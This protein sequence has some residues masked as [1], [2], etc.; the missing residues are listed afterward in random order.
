M[1]DYVL[2]IFLILFS[3]AFLGFAYTQVSKQLHRLQ[4]YNP[5]KASVIRT[6]IDKRVSYDDEQQRKRITYAPI[7]RYQY[8]TDGQTYESNQVHPIAIASNKAWAKS[9]IEPYR[10]GNSVTIYVDPEDPE[11]AYLIKHHSFFPYIFALGSMVFLSTGV[12]IFMN[13]W[14]DD[15]SVATKSPSKTEDSASRTG[16]LPFLKIQDLV[17]LSLWFI[18]G[19]ITSGHYFMNAPTSSKLA[20]TI[21]TIYF[22]MGLAMLLYFIFSERTLF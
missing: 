17:M 15:D 2:S 3:F 7:V 8:Q 1:K 21:T 22:G 16:G 4:A 12:F 5:Q 9:V 14:F 11:H 18:M 13:T 20:Y 10:K 19:S 6:A